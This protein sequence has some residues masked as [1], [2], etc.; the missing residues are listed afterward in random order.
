MANREAK[1]GD[2]SNGSSLSF[3]APLKSDI[4]LDVLLKMLPTKGNLVYEYNAFRNYRL[5]VDMFEYKSH[6]YTMEEL[7]EMGISS[8][9]SSWSGLP[10]TD[11][12]LLYEAGCLVDF[13]T[14]QLQFDINHPVDILPQYSYDGSVNLILND[15]KNI[16][17]LINSRF[18]SIGKNTYE[19]VDRK[20]DNDVNIYDRGKQFDIDT[21]L[22]KRV[23]E[24]PSLRFIG[25]TL[26]GNLPVGNYVFYFKYA[27]DDGNETDFVT[28]SG[29]VSMFVGTDMQSINGGVQDMNS[30]KMV[31]FVMDNIDPGYSYVIV[32]YTRVT[33]DVS[34][35]PIKS[36]HKIDRKFEVMKSLSCQISITGFDNVI[37]IPISDINLQYCIASSVET[38]ATAQNR[39]FLGNIHKPDI[40]YKELSDL[41]LRICPI[42]GTKRYTTIDHEYTD[43]VKNTYYDPDFIYN[44]T[45]YANNG[46]MY[47][48]AVVYILSDNTLSPAFF[49]RGGMD[50]TTIDQASL[51]Q[52]FSEIPI[53]KTINGVKQRVYIS[54]EESTGEIIKVTG[55][56]GYDVDIPDRIENSWGVTTLKYKA[57]GSDNDSN[58]IYSINMMIHNNVKNDFFSCLASLGIKGFFFV[59]QKRIPFTICQAIT[60]GLDKNSY[61]PVLPVDAK[62]VS[63]LGV[64]DVPEGD[65]CYIAERFMNDERKLTSEFIE[66][67]Y[68]LNKLSVSNKAAICPDYD[69]YPGYFNQIFNGSKFYATEANFSPVANRLS[70]NPSDNRHLYVEVERNEN[71]NNDSNVSTS[72][73]AIYDNATII[74]T[75]LNSWR[76]RAGEAEEAYRFEYLERENKVKAASNMVRGIF[77][78]YIGIEGIDRQCSII[79]IKSPE[80]VDASIYDKMQTRHADKSPFYA[81]SERYSLSSFYKND[82]ELFSSNI[83]DGLLS[84][85][86][87]GDSFICTFTHRFNRNFADPEAPN[88]NKIVDENTWVDNYNFDENDYSEINRGDVNAVQLGIWITFP[89]VSYRNLNIRSLDP[90]YPEEEGLTGHKRGFYPYYGTSTEGSFKIPES[91]VIN[92][93]LSVNL[94]ERWNMPVPD[95]PYIKNQF[96]TRILYSDVHVNDAFKNGFRVFQANSFQDYPRTYGAIVRL[97]ELSGNLICVYEHGVVLI[98]VNE[99]VQ[100]GEGSGGN[101]Y[102]NTNNIL[103]ENPKVLS[104]TFGTQWKESV[105]KTPYGIYGVDTVAK[106]IWR[107]NGDILEVISDFKIQEFLNINIS[108][109]E[110]E[111]TPIIGIRNVKSHY[112]AFKQDVMFTFYD[113]TVGFEEKVW[114]ICYNEI[115]NQWITFYSWLPSYSENIDNIYFS[116]D[117]NTSKWI[118]KLGMSKAGNDFSLGIT[119]DNNIIKK[120]SRRIGILG[121]AGVNIPDIKTG[122]SHS[123][124]YTIEHDN[125]GYYKMFNIKNEGGNSVLYLNDSVNYSDLV[126]NI[127]RMDEHTGRRVFLNRNDPN[128]KDTIVYQLNIRCEVNLSYQD[129][130]DTNIKQYVNGWQ[131]YKSM[132]MGTYDYSIAVIPEDN[133][134][135]L[136]TD[137]WKHGQSGIIDIKDKIV[138]CVWYAKQ[139]PFELEFVVV[140]DPSS[141]K[142][143]ENLQIISN[144]AEPE[145]F[146]FEIVGDYYEFADDKKNIFFRQ[147]AVKALYQYNG[148]DILFDRNFL[149]VI[150]EQRVMNDYNDK[151]TIFNLYYARQDTFN[152]IED[153]Y[154][155]VTSPGKDYTYLSGSEIIYYE[156]LNEY[157]IWTHIKANAINKVGRRLGNMWYQ[158]DKLF[159]Q[160][161]AIN[162]AEKNENTWREGTSEYIDSY[163]N[164]VRMHLPPLTV[165][166]SPIPNDIINTNIT[167]NDFPDE[168]KEL[169]YTIQDIDTSEWG[170]NYRNDA[171]MRKTTRIRDKYCKIRIRYS[172]GNPVIIRA[173]KTIYSDY[174]K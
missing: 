73:S 28:E 14:D 156:N 39:L 40:P 126:A 61:T 13:E 110:R 106:K 27:D 62:T 99:R 19:I 121:L 93:G 94:G 36:A 35:E 132:G 114:N 115:L 56:A 140:D 125:F 32:Y 107:T 33:G 22:Y 92:M 8:N 6:F 69:C 168:L 77:G 128:Y 134:M 101:V 111:L 9:G 135:F 63:E 149:N 88:N 43:D 144:F 137:F 23:V 41:S 86:Y 46:E 129:D 152:E 18:T 59:R 84:G 34:C 58:T 57:S 173:I 160:I 81:I 105:I 74:A 157:R 54:S 131:E 172:G 83:I 143:F 51:S 65:T 123:Y 26:G 102:I 4:S 139:H 167:N 16:P 112:N 118:S 150:P 117:R 87:R 71:F 136:T 31:R 164:T 163:G 116:F 3:T 174:N 159:V 15:G 96:Q 155:G 89:V 171:D 70:I 30:H 146:H 48:F 165:L 124:S 153:Y 82:N 20:G 72:V 17:R 91:G 66:H 42:V 2:F 68:V 79:N 151:S 47:V 76:G 169:G 148:S 25:V 108:L 80:A 158:E 142:V 154:K 38:Q 120:N 12:P 24:I 10:D 127:F 37:D 11:E 52:Q 75:S 145:S 64:Q 50:I 29:I 133:E 95:V 170:S 85:I 49:I 1:Y 55:D 162:F 161:P 21:S 141:H 44:Y 45:G 130:A 97:V 7:N 138:P 90:S 67:L 53:Y 5:D 109:T 113:N 78:N 103:P 100:A 60:I 147:E 166:N 98:P 104:H 122:I 119:L